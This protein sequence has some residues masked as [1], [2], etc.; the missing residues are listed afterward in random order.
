MEISSG[1]SAEDARASMESILESGFE[2]GIVEDA[3]IAESL[4]QQNAFWQLR[5]DMSDS[6][7]P[8]GASIKHDIAVPVGSLPKF[9]EEADAAVLKIVPDARIV[10]F[11]HMGD[12]N[13]HY[14]I[15]QP[16]GW[17]REQFFEF[18]PAVNDAVY[19][20]IAKYHGSISAEHGI[21]Q[22]KRDKLAKIKDPTALFL[23]R[24][25][26]AA[27]DPEGIMNPGKVI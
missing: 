27:L 20:L 11:G 26:K 24:K 5:E 17:E 23:M 22:M 21:G 9:I 1:Q 12:G 13:L 8:E 3:T 2:A 18:E 7:K 14:N 6:Q 16:V 15:S 10:N 4:A 25:I 19:D